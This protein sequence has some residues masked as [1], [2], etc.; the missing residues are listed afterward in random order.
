MCNFFSGILTREG[1]VFADGNT[2]GHEEIIKANKLDDKLAVDDPKRN[3]VRFELIPK[4]FYNQAIDS[5]TFK[6]DESSTPSWL[7]DQHERAARAYVQREYLNQK[8]YKSVCK[9]IEYVKTIKWFAPME[10]P[11]LKDL[12]K[13]V[14]AL[15]KAFKI[16]GKIR[17]KLIPFDG[18]AAGAAAWDAA[19]DAAWAAAWDA[20][21]DAARA[22]AGDAAWDAAWDAARDAAWD[23]ARAAA[24][25]AARA[26]EYEIGAEK[27]KKYKTNPFKLLVRLW[28]RG[29][30][31]CGIK[32]NILTLGYVL[33]EKK[34]EVNQK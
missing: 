7:N 1:K 19:W 24:W 33:K 3:W 22:A 14:M 9:E 8:W 28:A 30:Y 25:D 31:V 17:I 4:Q 26:A 13:D 12:Q 5:W 15:G 11:T 34:R 16:K 18:A 2:N 27:N 20:A 21:W 23:A 10:E 6:V 29:Y 32:N